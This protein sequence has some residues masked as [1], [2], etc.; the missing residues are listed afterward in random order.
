MSKG[1]ALKIINAALAVLIIT[2]VASGFLMD[3]IGETA[4]GIVHI[5]GGLLLV[6]CVI[7]HTALNWG[8][9]KANYFKR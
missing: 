6:A 3:E 9:V 1:Q 5:G 8:W 2:Q 7:T 4:F